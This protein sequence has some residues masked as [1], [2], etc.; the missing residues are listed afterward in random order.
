[1]Q[2]T[3]V[4]HYDDFST[5]CIDQDGART[6]LH[7]SKKINHLPCSTSWM[8]DLTV[9]ATVGG[10]HGT[11][12]WCTPHVY[13]LRLE[14]CQGV[15]TLLLLPDPTY[16]VGLWGRGLSLPTQSH[17]A[18][19]GGEW[20]SEKEKSYA[21]GRRSSR[22]DHTDPSGVYVHSGDLH[23]RQLHCHSETL[24]RPPSAKPHPEAL[25]VEGCLTLIKAVLQVSI[26]RLPCS[27]SWR[28]DLTVATAISSL[29]GNP[30]WGTPR[31]YGIRRE[32]C[33]GVAICLLPHPLG[34]VSWLGLSLPKGTLLSKPLFS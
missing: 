29:H 32:V 28:L 10:L 34:G 12:P 6:G 7:I 16:W 21:C 25:L 8:V 27:T 11:P 1:M 30:H 3:K 20:L 14:L 5:K 26:N 24:S 33:Q 9:A 13:G 17:Q 31:V 18:I 15:M 22:A 4:R 23:M 19:P 2:L